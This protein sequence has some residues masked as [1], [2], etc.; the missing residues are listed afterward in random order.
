MR[1]ILP[2]G[3]TEFDVHDVLNVFVSL[4]MLCTPMQPSLLL[5]INYAFFVILLS[6]IC[7]LEGVLL[8]GVADL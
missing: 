7:S 2:F 1:A 5:S 6:F 3:L 4:I 8:K